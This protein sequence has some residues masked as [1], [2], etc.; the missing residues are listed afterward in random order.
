MVLAIG[1]FSYIFLIALEI[2]FQP[3]S[4]TGQLINVCELID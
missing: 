1:T 2:L 3:L 4:G